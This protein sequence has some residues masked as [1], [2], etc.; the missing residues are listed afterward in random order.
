MITQTPGVYITEKNNYPASVA[1]VSTAVPVFIGYTHTHQPDAELVKGMFD[2]ER[3]FGGSFE[4]TFHVNPADLKVSPNRRF[5]LYDALDLYFKNGGGECHVVSLGKYGDFDPAK[6]ID[7]FAAGIDALDLVDEAT[8]ALLPDLHLQYVDGSGA[9]TGLTDGEFGTLSSALIQKCATLKNQFALLDVRDM[10]A[11]VNGFRDRVSPTDPDNL[12]HGAV[13]YP[14]LNVPAVYSLRYDQ[15]DYAHS[16]TVAADIDS[17]NVDIT[18]MEGH[19]MQRYDNASQKDEMLYLLKQIDTASPTAKKTPTTNLFKFLFGRVKKLVTLG[20]ALSSGSLLTNDFNDL[21]GDSSLL[22]REISKLY[23]LAEVLKDDNHVSAVNSTNV[24][25]D[26]QWSGFTGNATD[27]VAD[28]KT[29]TNFDPAQPFSDYDTF[30]RDFVSGLY[31]D[32]DIIFSAI[33]GL[34]HKATFRKQTLEDE[35][36]ATD[37][38]YQTIRNN[39]VQ[40]MQTLPSQGAIAGLYCRNDRERGI[41]KSP[42]NLSIAGA[43]PVLEVSNSEQDGLN[44][45]PIGG[46]SVNV[47]RTFTGKGPIVWG[48]RTLAGNSGEWKYIAVRRFYS[49][50]EDSVSKALN[51]MVFEPNNARTWVK[52]KAMITSFLVQQWEAGALTGASMK[53]AFFVEIGTT[54]TQQADIDNGIINVRVGMAVARPAEFVIL[55]FSHKSV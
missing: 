13:Y 43:S 1:G 27:I 3:L 11:G 17:L 32:T 28:L 18:A 21:K 20:G 48:A 16:S 12:K 46:K 47:I 51:S 25:T 40:Y 37:A 42:A 29:D 5:M 39:V 4:P 9:L 35:L 26:T 24:L 30:V 15:V 53:E 31:I 7:Q 54:T 49:Y 2:F 8:L 10:V 52:I 34:Y 14:W 22:H 6:I 36:F 19:L 44:V 38:D 23:R 50:V 33:S 55:E 41:W 45:D